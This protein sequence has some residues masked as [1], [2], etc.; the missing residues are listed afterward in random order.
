MYRSAATLAL[1][2]GLP[3]LAAAIGAYRLRPLRPELKRPALLLPLGVFAQAVLGGLTVLLHLSW[4]V[5]IAHYL[6]SILLLVAGATLVWRVRRPPGA[7][8]PTH[9]RPT[10]MGTRALAAYGGLVL[11]AGSFATAAGP[12]AGGAGAG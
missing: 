8:A 1:L 6:L 9:A 7:A 2:V 11:A 10:V 3:A 12:H 5:V 4:E